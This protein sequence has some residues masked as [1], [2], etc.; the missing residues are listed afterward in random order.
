MAVKGGGIPSREY[1]KLRDKELEHIK[2]S[3]KSDAGYKSQLTRIYNLAQEDIEKE[4]TRDI[5][6]FAYRDEVSMVEARKIISKTD[7][8]S[9]RDRAKQYVGEKNFSPRA[10]RELRA[11]NITMRSNRLELLQS[12]IHLNTVALA[13]QE[14][15]LLQR[16]LA[17]EVVNEY[18]RQ[19]GILNMS[20]PSERQLDRIARS[21]VEAEFRNVEFSER[22]WAN[23]NDL[24]YELENGL[25]RSIIRGE[26]PRATARGLRELVSDQFENKKYAA[27]RIAIT[28]TARIQTETQKKAFEDAGIEKMVWIAEPDACDDC[29]ENDGQIFDVDDVEALIPLHPFCKCSFAGYVE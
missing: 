8:E 3:L 4:I 24:Q 10:N 28:E 22:I 2:E 12:K 15:Y 6:G 25:R 29:A 23:Q 7:V 16:H 18:S 5:L 19:A 13:N 21:L 9:F 1:W 17:K 11:Y 26:N 27:D 14:E 20:I